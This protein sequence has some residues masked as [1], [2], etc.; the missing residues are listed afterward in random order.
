MRLLT[1]ARNCKEGRRGGDDYDKNDKR[2]GNSR[3]NNRVDNTLEALG[4]EYVKDT[5]LGDEAMRGVSGGQRRRVTLVEVSIY[6]SLC[7]GTMLT[8]IIIGQL[9]TFSFHYFSPIHKQMLVFEIPLLCGDEISTGLV[10]ASTIDI[11]SIS[12]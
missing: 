7:K 11:L 9:F 10:M 4:L 3:G 6:L 5:F 8:C 2:E 12:R 1:F